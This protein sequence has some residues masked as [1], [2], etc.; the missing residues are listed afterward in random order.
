L[1]WLG[2]QGELISFNYSNRKAA[3]LGETLTVGGTILSVD[4]QAHTVNL[5]LSVKNENGEVITPGSAQLKVY[6]QAS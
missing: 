5:Q 2:D 3:Y 1:N 6:D 4:E